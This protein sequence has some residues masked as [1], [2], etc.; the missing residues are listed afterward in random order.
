MLKHDPQ[1]RSRS[2]LRRSSDYSEEN[3]RVKKSITFQRLSENGQ[4]INECTLKNILTHLIFKIFIASESSN[5]DTRS[6]SVFESTEA[7]F[8]R[9]SFVGNKY[10]SD[11]SESE[12]DESLQEEEEKRLEEKKLYDA[13][14]KILAPYMV[15]NDL[16]DAFLQRVLKNSADSSDLNEFKRSVEDEIELLKSK[17][18]SDENKE[19]EKRKST[20]RQ[21]CRDINECIE[22]GLV[23]WADDSLYILAADRTVSDEAWNHKI[24]VLKKKE[25]FFVNDEENIEE[26]R[27]TMP[28][29]NLHI[30]TKPNDED[31]LTD[32]IVKD[33]K[34]KLVKIKRIPSDRN[35]SQRDIE[36]FAVKEVDRVSLKEQVET[37]DLE[38]PDVAREQLN[39]IIGSLQLLMTKLHQKRSVD[40]QSE[41]SQ[42]E[43]FK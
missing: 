13:K 14:I 2:I 3:I 16:P 9:Y 11:S 29:M 4:D 37:L 5:E 41:Y 31:E 30:E 34:D 21:R 42:T 26:Y 17:D 27:G 18:E 15:E 43:N 24:N 8:R 39:E 33:N 25:E 32:R 10:C 40:P 6:R 12:E 36:I 23:D 20:Y 38:K 1:I 22:L 7:S 28:T 35:R 19:E